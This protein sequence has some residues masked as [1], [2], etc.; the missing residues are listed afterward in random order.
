MHLYDFYEVWSCLYDYMTPRLVKSTWQ[1]MFNLSPPEIPG[2]AGSS[3]QNWQEDYSVNKQRSLVTTTWGWLAF[4]WCHLGSFK[5]VL[6]FN[7][8][9]AFPQ[10]T[11]LFKFK[12][13]ILFSPLDAEKPYPNS[14]VFRR[15][16]NGDRGSFWLRQ[17]V[18]GR[19]RCR[20][21]VTSS[22]ITGKVSS[23]RCRSEPEPV[24]IQVDSRVIWPGS[25]CHLYSF[26]P[27]FGK[28]VYRL[29]LTTTKV[30]FKV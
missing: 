2:G 22:V 4:S 30:F 17:W 5:K 10:Y 15:H 9:T 1:A 14:P 8:H 24:K 18:F 26:L 28:R 23:R 16:L 29:I 11:W 3:S 7:F 12:H 27:L 20:D 25:E 6:K 19:L 13:N 21:G